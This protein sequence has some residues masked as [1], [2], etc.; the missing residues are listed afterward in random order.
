MRK[1]F[2]SIL[3]I[4]SISA[5]AQTGVCS[6]FHRKNCNANNEKTEGDWTYNAQSKSGLFT[7]GMTSK[8]KC[9]VYK[10]MDYRINVCC[11]SKLGNQLN[12]KIYDGRTNKLLYDNATEKNKPDFIF[13]SATTRQLV[14]ELTVPNLSSAEKVKGGD[15]SPIDADC[16]GLLI[17]NKITNKQG[18]STY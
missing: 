4:S 17:E 1:L 6:E 3:F 11:E 16:V 5:V 13:Q 15:R 18:F 12:Y 2:L 9:V 8:I 7:Q 14:I 10:G